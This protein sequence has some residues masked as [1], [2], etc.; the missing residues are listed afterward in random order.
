[1]SPIE[2]EPAA[3]EKSIFDSHAFKIIAWIIIQL[4]I[5]NGRNWNH[6]ICCRP[7]GCHSQP[8]S[9]SEHTDVGRGVTVTPV[10]R[11]GNLQRL[12]LLHKTRPRCT[13]L[14]R[15]TLRCSGRQ[16]T[17]SEHSFVFH[18]PQEIRRHG[19]IGWRIH[20]Q[21]RRLLPSSKASWS[22]QS[23]VNS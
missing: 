12:L 17:N 22:V 5:M 2:S 7:G 3:A 16:V 13:E 14:I 15:S 23:A 1:M 11:C 21:I 19:C 10:T 4:K 20:S 18:V 6:R 8:P 9:Q